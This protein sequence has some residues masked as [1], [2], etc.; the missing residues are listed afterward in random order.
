MQV[1][2]F[3]DDLMVKLKEAEEMATRPSH[4]RLMDELAQ[5]TLQEAEQLAGRIKDE[6]QQIRAEAEAEIARTTSETQKTAQEMVEE[7]ERLVVKLKD[8][9]L[10]IRTEAQA[11]M[12]SAV[13]DAQRSTQQQAEAAGRVA[14]M[15]A[16]DAQR[17][18]QDARGMAALIKAEGKR[19]AERLLEHTKK[20]IKSQVLLYSKGASEKL[21]PYLDE[22]IRE[23]QALSIELDWEAT[24]LEINRVAPETAEV[25]PTPSLLE[26]ENVSGK[27]EPEPSDATVYLGDVQLAVQ[28][29]VSSLGLGKICER[30]ERLPGITVRDTQSV[31][32][33]SYTINLSLGSPTL[34]L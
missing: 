23:V 27:V 19:Q 5:R 26:T 3:V 17:V 7:G 29:P 18:V 15:A 21:V 24:A 33:G 4:L 34:L 11:H 25:Q 12:A 16:E 22:I 30:L 10:Q 31:H 9:A 1:T 2:E 20:R 8:E 14:K 28:P 13:A 6:A 32:D